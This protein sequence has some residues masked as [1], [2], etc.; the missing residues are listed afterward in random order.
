MTNGVMEK[1]IKFLIPMNT[2]KL[3]ELR[4]KLNSLDYFNVRI[5]RYQYFSNTLVRVSHFFS[6]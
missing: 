5:Q 2:S 1:E 4:L 3:F 6:M